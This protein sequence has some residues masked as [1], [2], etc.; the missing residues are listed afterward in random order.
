[1]GGGA[2]ISP[3]AQDCQQQGGM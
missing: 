2:M 1:M 3:L